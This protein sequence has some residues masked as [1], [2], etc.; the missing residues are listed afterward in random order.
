VLL[1]VIRLILENTRH[2]MMSYVDD[3]TLGFQAAEVF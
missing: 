3:T 1:E 2:L